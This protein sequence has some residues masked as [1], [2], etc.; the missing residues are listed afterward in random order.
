MIRYVNI[1]PSDGYFTLFLQLLQLY[2]VKRLIKTHRPI[3][4]IFELGPK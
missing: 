3:M 1:Q 2:L 4:L